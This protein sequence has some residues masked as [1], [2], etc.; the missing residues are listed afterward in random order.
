M[1]A[2]RR[3]A[4]AQVALPAREPMHAQPAAAAPEPAAFGEVLGPRLR[5]GLREGPA[6]RVLALRRQKRGQRLDGL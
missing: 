5:R 3:D 4:V 2:G 1:V 6:D